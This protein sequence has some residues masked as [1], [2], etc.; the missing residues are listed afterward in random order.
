MRLGRV[1]VSHGW[2]P[3]WKSGGRRDCSRGGEGR[4]VARP[5]PEKERLGEKER[6]NFSGVVLVSQMVFFR[7]MG[8]IGVLI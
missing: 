3:V 5:R 6:E 1:S 8:E 4:V 2:G 7:N